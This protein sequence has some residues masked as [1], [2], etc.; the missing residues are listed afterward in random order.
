MKCL[1]LLSDKLLLVMND[2]F[3]FFNSLL[4][5]SHDVTLSSVIDETSYIYLY[6]VSEGKDCNFTMVTRIRD[7]DKIK[8]QGVENQY[9]ENFV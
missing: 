5:H 4:E 2:R 7:I 3:S 6:L 9:I 8:S 1:V